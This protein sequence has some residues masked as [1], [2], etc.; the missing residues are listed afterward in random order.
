LRNHGKIAVILKIFRIQETSKGRLLLLLQNELPSLFSIAEYKRA[1][2][3]SSKSDFKIF[4]RAYPK[5]CKIWCFAKVHHLPTN[6][7]EAETFLQN[8]RIF[9][10]NLNR[11]RAHS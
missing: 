3:E 11:K 8:S 5:S 7:Y 9:P 4:S 2:R 6:L 10:P 1:L